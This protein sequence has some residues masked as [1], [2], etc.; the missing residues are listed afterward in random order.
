MWDGSD[1]FG[2]SIISFQK[3]LK[4]FGY[5]LVYCENMGIN[6]FFIHDIDSK[7]ELKDIYTETKYVKHR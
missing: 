1:Y 5:T 4:L 3:M 7:F 6:A 2:A